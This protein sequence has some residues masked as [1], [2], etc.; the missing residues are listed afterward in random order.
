[1]ILRFTLCK[2]GSL[3]PVYDVSNFCI[4]PD[5]YGIIHSD[6]TIHFIDSSFA[7][8]VGGHIS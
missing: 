4:Y 8:L 2:D 7:S 5:G 6:G 3:F 1:M